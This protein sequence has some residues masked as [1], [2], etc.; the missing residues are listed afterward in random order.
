M[1]YVSVVMDYGRTR[2]DPN[3]WTRPAFTEFKQIITRL[4]KLNETLAQPDCHDPA[5]AEW[6][7]QVEAR[8]TRLEAA[9]SPNTED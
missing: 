6:M 9:G 4:D 3:Q 5:K 2:I 1:C 7:A 8:L